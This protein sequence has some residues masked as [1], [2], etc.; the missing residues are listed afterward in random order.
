MREAKPEPH[1]RP[2]SLGR[3]HRPVPRVSFTMQPGI[4]VAGSG[5]TEFYY[6][7]IGVIRGV[8]IPATSSFS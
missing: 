2:G 8:R 5:T 3:E 7:V 1:E 6:V 4:G